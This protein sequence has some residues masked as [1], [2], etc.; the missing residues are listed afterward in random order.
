ML[1]EE[2]IKGVRKEPNVTISRAAFLFGALFTL[3]PSVATDFKRAPLDFNH[4]VSN[5]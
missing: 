2:P 3:V 1:T 4:S 5:N